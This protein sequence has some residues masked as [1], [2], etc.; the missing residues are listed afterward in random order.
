MTTEELSKFLEGLTVEQVQGI[1]NADYTGL[2]QKVEVLTDAVA[3]I[4]TKVDDMGK[5][6]AEEKTPQEKFNDY[7]AGCHGLTKI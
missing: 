6:G 4:N 7:L 3:N 5:D 1:I 2:Q